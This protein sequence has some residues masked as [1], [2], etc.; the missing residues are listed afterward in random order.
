MLCHRPITRSAIT[1]ARRRGAKA[2]RSL[3]PIARSP[4]LCHGSIA[5]SAIAHDKSSVG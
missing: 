5:R 3:R 4:L 2:H 1:D